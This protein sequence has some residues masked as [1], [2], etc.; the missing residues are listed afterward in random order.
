MK[1]I[2]HHVA[3]MLCVLVIGAPCLASGQQPPASQPSS[4]E[5]KADK[6]L[7][8]MGSLLAG[9]KQI[10]FNA[11]AI[12]DQ[13]TAEGQKVQYAKNQKVLLR[14]PNMLAVDVTGDLE[15]LAFRYDGKRVTLYNPRTRSWGSAGAPA[16]I[17]E[18]L[19]ML[20]DKY[21]MPLPLA[22]VVF[23]DPYK[24]L[25]ENVRSGQYLGDGWVFDA[26]C[27]HLA[28]RQSAVDWQIWVEQGERP[29]PRKIVITFKESPGHPQYTAFLSN[30]NLSADAPDS[31]FTFT[32]PAGAKQVEFAPQ[33]PTPRDDAGGTKPGGSNSN[34]GDKR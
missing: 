12:G 26:K 34:G 15:E 19:D 8:D 13:Y 3:A 2:L 4:I 23:A 25:T 31:A 24:C 16:S 32:A 17:D 29:L 1:P 6:V 33:A 20:A 14:R 22:D 18:T 9:R 30:W 28:F 11:H 5:P 21:G 10:S 27:H 7:R